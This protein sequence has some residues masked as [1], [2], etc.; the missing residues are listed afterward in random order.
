MNLITQEKKGVSKD[1]KVWSKDQKVNS[2]K[3]NQLILLGIVN[4]AGVTLMYSSTP[5]V[6]QQQ[7]LTKWF[8]GT[9]QQQG[10]NRWSS[11]PYKTFSIDRELMLKGALDSKTHKGQWRPNDEKSQIASQGAQGFILEARDPWG[12][13]KEE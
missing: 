11:E 8:L 3:S 2:E 13:L 7:I 6:I 12:I 4:E 10:R 5:L 9:R 1:I